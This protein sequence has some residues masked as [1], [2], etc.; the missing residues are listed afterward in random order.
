MAKARVLITRPATLQADLKRLLE[1]SDYLV[2][3][4]PLLSIKPIDIDSP[5]QG[6]VREL[7]LNLDLYSKIVFIS[8]HAARIGADIID[9]YW[10]QL[11]MNVHWFA[12]GSGTADELKRFNISVQVN[13][14]IDSESLLSNH[15]LQHLDDQRILIIK[16]IGGRELLS[17]K[18]AERGAKVDLAEVYQRQLPDYTDREIAERIS[19]PVDV[20]LITSGE[21]LKNLKRLLS[22][23]FELKETPIIVPSLRIAQLAKT[24][25]FEQRIVAEGADNH[26]MLKALQIRFG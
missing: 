19:A 20:V 13:K 21:A 6:A 9:H 7:F 8:R 4:L 14:G 1:N 26:A 10:P 22:N 3:S 12:I 17:Q 16:G 25:G 15:A 5:D 23:Q 2:Q 24:L 11:P 18:L